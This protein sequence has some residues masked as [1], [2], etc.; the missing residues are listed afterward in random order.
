MVRRPDGTVELDHNGKSPGRGAYLHPA[1]G[2]VEVAR[3]RLL[4]ERALG[5]PVGAE[6]WVEVLNSLSPA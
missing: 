5:A 2:C 6:V 4:L 1:T 3:K